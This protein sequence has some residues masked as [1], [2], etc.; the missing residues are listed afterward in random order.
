[1][2]PQRVA[3]VTGANRGLGLAVSR[4]L[5]DAG[6]AV[7]LVGRRSLELE[8]IARELAAEGA[9]AASFPADVTEADDVGRL[10]AFVE[11]RMGRADILINNAGVFL[12]PKDFSRPAGILEVTPEQMLGTLAANTVAPLRLIQAFLPLMR[13]HGYGRIVNVSSS[14]GRLADMGAGW[15]GYRASKT[16]LNALTRV[17]AAELQ[18]ENIKINS[19]CPGWCRTDMGGSEANRSPEEGAASIVWAALLPADGP[20]GG[21]FRDWQPLDW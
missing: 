17:V 21:F 3:I 10:R 7:V 19:V 6:C 15:P 12:E 8:A 4:Q 5:A 13:A 1:M 11:A 14:M 16:A 18:G 9:T 20:S 2:D